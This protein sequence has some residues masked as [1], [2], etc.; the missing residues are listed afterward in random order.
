MNDHM[1]LHPSRTKLKSFAY[2]IVLIW[3][4]FGVGPGQ[5]IGNNFFGAPD[6]GYESWIL[7]IPSLW[8]YQLIWWF[9]G[10]GLIWFLANKMDLSTLPNKPIKIGDLHKKPDEVLGEVNYLDK[11][12]TGY[13]WILILIGITLLVITL[14]AYLV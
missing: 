10:I 7:K 4:F 14:F 6:A 1:G 9:F 5:V 3:L 11:L 13:G 2:V 12:G 8:G